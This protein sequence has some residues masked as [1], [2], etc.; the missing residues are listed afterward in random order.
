[1]SYVSEVRAD[2]P[3]AWF[4]LGEP[5]GTTAVD[6]VGG[7]AG[8]YVGD[9]TL[10]Q[11]GLITDGDT[12]ARFNATTYSGYVRV[13]D[14][15]ALDLGSAGSVEAWVYLERTGSGLDVTAAIVDKGSGSL[16][17]R[18]VSA[19]DL[20]LLVRRNGVA[21]IVTSR[22]ALTLRTRAHV[23]VTWSGTT[24]RIYIN[25]V[26]QTG[27]VTS[28]TLANTAL[29]FCIGAADGGGNDRWAG[30]IDEVAIYPTALS[31]GRVLAHYN[32][33]I[34]TAATI[35]GAATMTGV[36]TI[37]GTGAR[38]ARG[39]AT[40]AG[41]GTLAAAGTRTTT[42]Q[43]TL[44]GAGA[45]G[46]TGRRVATNG[47]LLIGGGSLV[48]AG[49]R[50]ATGTAALAGS[51]GVTAAGVRA[52][53]SGAAFAGGATLT[54]AGSRRAQSTAT[55]GGSGTLAATG[56]RL[57]F[58]SAAFAGTGDLSAGG[59]G[60]RTISGSVALAGQGA[61]SAAG[62]RT[63]RGATTIAG[64]ATLAAAGLRTTASVASMAGSAT[65][66]AVGARSSFG[67]ASLT[68]AGTL[69]ATAVDLDLGPGSLVVEVDR[70]TFAVAVL[71]PRLAVDVRRPTLKT[72]VRP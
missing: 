40:M 46:A 43:T 48:A 2:S 21:N 4:R 44:P 12:A 69:T 67:T 56:S 64:S 70:A 32:A 45:I 7:A 33:G 51:G 11:P 14:R 28:S 68:G 26:D 5:S 19:S 16:I 53:T 24:W 3:S 35:A 37:A 8:A 36:G 57:A 1:M 71:T 72:E 55:L 25:G 49:A 22:V 47:A 62:V 58:G 6:T 60:Q 41:T 23:V 13:A 52:T 30:Y 39:Q 54:A 15:A 63:G 42:A 20:R 29:P 66:T 31:A 17:V 61:M 65:I 18:T 38:T 27:T 59:A 9:V 10:A 34:A 50:S